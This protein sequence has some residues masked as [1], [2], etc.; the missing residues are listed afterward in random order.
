M[1]YES[2]QPLKDLVLIEADKP[3]EKTASGIY[4]TEDWKTLPPMGTVKAVGPEVKDQS[5][6]GKRVLF[7]RYASVI[8]EGQDRLCK[9]S[10]ILAILEDEDADR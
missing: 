2:M 6:V 8:L 1:Y 9:E 10:C 3:K 7:E 5:L 4:I